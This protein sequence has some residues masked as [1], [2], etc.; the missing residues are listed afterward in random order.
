VW[1]ARC[2][3]VF[4]VSVVV[5]AAVPAAMRRWGLCPRSPV[6]GSCL[7]GV[8]ISSS[9]VYKCM[10]LCI[11]VCELYTQIGIFMNYICSYIAEPILAF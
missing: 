6:V 9:Y 8:F 5:G 7:S 3:T 11:Y 4:P 10:Y 1:L 2:E